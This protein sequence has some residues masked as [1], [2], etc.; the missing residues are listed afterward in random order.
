MEEKLFDLV[1]GENGFIVL[2]RCNNEFDEGKYCDIKNILL[3]LVSEWQQQEAIPK[4]AM[5]A[6]SE[7]IECLVR[8]N[9]FL[10]EDEAIRVE[11]ASIEIRDIINNLYENL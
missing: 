1:L 6:I 3:I 9:S 8:G 2:L 5:L 4:K 11:D 10:D 7:L